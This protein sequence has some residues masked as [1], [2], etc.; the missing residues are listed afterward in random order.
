VALNVASV[1]CASVLPP[2]SSDS[3][4]VSSSISLLSRASAASLPP[5]SR[6]RKYCA[7]TKTDSRK[8]KTSSRVESAST[9]PGQ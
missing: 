5:T 1:C 6:A 8:M 7:I 9:K 2:F 3:S 4:E